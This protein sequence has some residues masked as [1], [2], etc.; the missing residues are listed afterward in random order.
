[1]KTY[2]FVYYV[3]KKEFVGLPYSE[4]V[5]WLDSQDDNQVIRKKQ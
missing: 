5:I 3:T 2:K 1:M 4:F